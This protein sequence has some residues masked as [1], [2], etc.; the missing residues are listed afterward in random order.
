MIRMLSG[1]SLRVTVRDSPILRLRFREGEADTELASL[2]LAGARRARTDPPCNRTSPSTI[3]SPRPNPPSA[4]SSDDCNCTKGSN[5]ASSISAER[6]MPWS[7]TRITTSLSIDVRGQLDGIVGLRILRRVRQEIHEDLLQA[8][9]VPVDGNLRR[10]GLDH[11]RLPRGVDLRTHDIDG[12][13]DHAAQIEAFLAQ[14]DFAARHSGD[15]EQ[16]FEQP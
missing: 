1:P 6:P 2:S 4:R 15:V 10:R 7:R 5:T 9:G 14:L 8:D 16:I 13:G 11:E 3:A 12:I